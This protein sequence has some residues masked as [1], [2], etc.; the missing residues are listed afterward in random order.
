MATSIVDRQRT[1]KSLR[2]EALAQLAATMTVP[3]IADLFGIAADTARARLAAHG[4]VARPVTRRRPRSTLN[5]RQLIPCT[6]N[7][8]LGTACGAP[9]DPDGTCRWTHQHTAG[10]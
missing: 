8:V 9:L 1:W 2:R 3:E 6:A 7:T 4:L 5:H 10:Q